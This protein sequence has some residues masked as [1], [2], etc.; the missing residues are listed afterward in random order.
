MWYS[1]GGGYEQRNTLLCEAVRSGRNFPTFRRNVLSP[2]TECRSIL[3]LEIVH[4]SETSVDYFPHHMASGRTRQHIPYKK[5]FSVSSDFEQ[6]RTITDSF[7]WAS[8][9]ISVSRPRVTLQIFI[10]G[11]L[12]M[13]IVQNNETHSNWKPT[14]YTVYG[15]TPLTVFNQSSTRCGPAGPLSRRFQFAMLQGN[16]THITVYPVHI[17]SKS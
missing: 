13:T 2:F 17:F 1:E 11:D 7:V 3:K 4:S 10:G 6:H 15:E 9:S 5:F 14:K 8:R 12:R 16:K